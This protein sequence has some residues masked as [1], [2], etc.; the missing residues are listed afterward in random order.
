M[1]RRGLCESRSAAAHAIEAKSVLVNGSLADK[2]SRLVAAGDA[3]VLT[4]QPRFVS[5]GGEKLDAA[6]NSFDIETEGVDALDLGASTGGFTDCLIQR[7]AASVVAVDV[8]HNQLHERLRQDPRV[9]SFEKLHL[10]DADP[11]LIGGPF[12]LVVCD[13]SFISLRQ[14]ARDVA[15]NCAPSADV[16]LLVKPQFEAGKAEVSKTQGVI[17]DDSVRLRTLNEVVTEYESLGFTMVAVIDS[18]VPGASG[19]VE[20]LVHLKAPATEGKRQ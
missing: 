7:G 11:Q 12:K 20:W 18:P 3:I 8:G 15:R 10:R 17:R 19:N 1:V 9:R 14:V 6:L 4:V 2:A 5:R 13:L 16:I